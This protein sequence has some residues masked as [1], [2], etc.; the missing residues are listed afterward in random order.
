MLKY[1][2][3]G[4]NFC[5][6]ELLRQNGIKNY[7]FDFLEPDKRLAKKLLMNSWSGLIAIIYPP[8]SSNIVCG[9]ER[10]P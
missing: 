3:F 5:Q 10:I 6:R 8:S 7:D 9:I 2:I 1:T 4:Q